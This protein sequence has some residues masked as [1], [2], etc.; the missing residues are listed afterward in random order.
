MIQTGFLLLTLFTLGF[1]YFVL[2]VENDVLTLKAEQRRA[3]IDRVVRNSERLE[4]EV[5]MISREIEQ[6]KR[7]SELSSL[8][9]RTILGVVLPSETIY[10]LSSNQN[11]RSP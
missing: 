6:L 9:A 2:F 5:Y 7:D 1:S 8:I 3:E 11:R 10:Q 4:S